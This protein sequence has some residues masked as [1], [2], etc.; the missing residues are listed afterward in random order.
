MGGSIGVESTVGRGST[1][2]LELPETESSVVRGGLLPSDTLRSLQP[3]PST[4]RSVLYI[5]DNIDSYQ[6]MERIFAHWPGVKLLTAM[7]G[8]L[9]LDLARQHR[10]DLILLDLHL[11]DSRA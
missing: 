1:F 5:E 2:W 3:S 4:Q 7:Q 11:P 8:R 6:L 9:G 10:P